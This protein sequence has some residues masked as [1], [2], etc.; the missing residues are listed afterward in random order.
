MG[1]LGCYICGDP[2]PHAWSMCV[3]YFCSCI[4]LSRATPLGRSRYHTSEFPTTSEFPA[5]LP[6][7]TTPRGVCYRGTSLVRNSALLGPYSRPMPGTLRWSWGGMLFLM[8]EVPLY[9]PRMLV[10]V[11]RKDLAP[12]YLMRVLCAILCVGFA[13]LYTYFEAKRATS[14]SCV[15]KKWRSGRGDGYNSKKSGRIL[16]EWFPL[17]GTSGTHYSRRDD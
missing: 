3:A 2:R 10:A 5:E 13:L 17:Q 16:F 11:H 14:D 12:C 6:T 1:S 8:S 15:I 4:S 7:R 9:I